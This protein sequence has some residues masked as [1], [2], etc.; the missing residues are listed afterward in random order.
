MAAG[1]DFQFVMTRAKEV[2][3]DPKGIWEKIKAEPDSVTDIYLKYAIVIFAIPAICFFLGM[4]IFG[5]TVPFVGPIKWPFFGGLI[6]TVV[7][8]GLQ[9]VGL[10]LGAVIL[11]KL[12][13][14]FGGSTSLTNTFKLVVY[15]GT[16]GAL[17]GIF[18]I[19]PSLAFIGGLVGGIY[20]IYTFFKGLPLM[21]GVP[22]GKRAGYIVVSILAAIVIGV[23]LQFVTRILLPDLTPMPQASEVSLPNGM[24]IQLNIP[25]TPQ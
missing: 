9:L 8:L 3:A 12:A 16:A 23:L 11:E 24:K 15:S 17:G 22:A 19:I 1:F 10:L 7:S 21:S 18:G 2:L 25:Q 20:S 13:P 5:I 4:V 6:H 14:K